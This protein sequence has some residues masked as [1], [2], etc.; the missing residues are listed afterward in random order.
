MDVSGVRVG[1]ELAGNIRKG[2]QKSRKI[3]F[4]QLNTLSDSMKDQEFIYNYLQ[5]NYNIKVSEQ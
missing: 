3:Y 5:F 1:K 4:Y 2:M